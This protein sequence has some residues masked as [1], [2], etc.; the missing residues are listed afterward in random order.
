MS[1]QAGAIDLSGALDPNGTGLES[2]LF[3][4]LNTLLQPNNDITPGTAAQLINK[5]VP[6]TGTGPHGN[7]RVTD[8]DA[9]EIVWAVWETLAYVSTLVPHD[10]EGQDTLVELLKSLTGL[11]RQITRKFWGVCSLSHL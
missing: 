11:P 9:E 7:P 4:I 1:L 5:L 6:A 8:D 3:E 10:H 2:N